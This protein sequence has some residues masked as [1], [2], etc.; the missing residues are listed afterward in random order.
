MKSFSN[1]LKALW[2]VVLTLFWVNPAQAEFLFGGEQTVVDRLDE[3]LYVLAERAEVDALIAGDMVLIAQDVLIGE[4]GVVAGNSRIMAEEVIVEGALGSLDEKGEG[5]AVTIAATRVLVNGNVAGDLEIRADFIT[6]G[7]DAFIDGK[8][9]YDS[10]NEPNIDIRSEITGDVVREGR[11]FDRVEGPWS[12]V[13][14]VYAGPSAAILQAIGLFAW[15]LLVVGFG[16]LLPD[17]VARQV[18]NLKARPIASGFF[19]LILPPGMVMIMLLLTITVI[20]IPLV[21]LLA[22]AVVGA[23]MLAYLMAHVVLGEIALRL[24][25]RVIAGLKD[26][27]PAGGSRRGILAAIVGLLLA[28][29]LEFLGVWGWLIMAWLTLSV[30]GVIFLKLVEQRQ[31]RLGLEK[32]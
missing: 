15:A 23:F 17:F 16:A 22:A 4:G 6:I 8:L 31:D 1:S 10:P 32:L 18:T 11:L 26:R 24:G 21:G 19:G 9:S 20:G 29:G 13:A 25:G 3:D 27:L 28:I 2:L 30:I 5:S 14:Y 7:P 12:G